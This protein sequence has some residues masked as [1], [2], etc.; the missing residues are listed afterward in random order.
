MVDSLLAVRLPETS[1]LLAA[2]AALSGDEVLRRRV[3]REI[4]D[5]AD[6]LP[7][8]LADLH[9]A[10]A[11]PRAVEVT[12]VLGDGD[13]VLVAA[14]LLELP[15]IMLESLQ[16]AVGSEA[17]LDALDAEPLPDEPFTWHAVQA[18][19]HDRVGEVLALIDRCCAELLD[20]EYRTACR[21][22]LADA[23]AGDPQIFRRR[24]KAATAAAAICW[25]AG[26]ANSLFDHEPVTP[27]MLVKDLT[28]H[29]GTAG[30]SVS[31]RSEPLLRAISINP[32]QYGR[33]DLGSPRYLTGQ[34][35]AR[36]LA[37]RDRY[38]AMKG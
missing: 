7:R 22:L 31:Q 37:H 26:K 25:I 38:R 36:I 23:A 18:D 10:T 3:H 30:A 27:K 4:T 2:V 24:G 34:R 21:R 9:R 11:L 15:D 28:G 17:A 29:F 20:G 16:R 8:W 13:N 5:R 19:V 6:A 14:T 33:M 1:A 32:H 35:R 12:H